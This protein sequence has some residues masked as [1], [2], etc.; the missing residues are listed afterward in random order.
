MARFDLQLL[1][2]YAPL[3]GWVMGGWLLGRWLP[4]T[5]PRYLGQGLFWVGVP[6]SII[7]FLRRANLSGA[8]WIA[9]IIAWLAIFLGVGL[10]WL[11]IQASLRWTN[12]TAKPPQVW[13]RSSQGSFLLTAMVGNT[14]YLGYP[15]ILTLVGP[16]YF[17]WA[18]FYDMLGTLLGSYG[19]GVL[20]AAQYGQ[21]R[22]STWQLMG[23]IAQNPA[24][25]SFGIGL[26][27]RQ[28]PLPPTLEIL[29]QGL[30]WTA[31]TLSLILIGMRLSQL[32][33]WR[34]LPRAS[35]SLGIKMLIVPLILG[36]GLTYLHLATP[37]Q[38]T[39]V[40]QTAMPPA[41]ATLVISEAYDLDR[42]L[43]VTTL[44]MGS[45]GL[46]VMLPVWLWLFGT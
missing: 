10:A 43:T 34:S 9:P 5:A 23:A 35:V 1:Q 11:W 31:L 29:L 4:A 13:N 7:A 38:L 36:W 28:V 19:F 25:W 21:R 15:I 45:V 41:F 46:L 18:L 20:L 3:I 14:G 32:T 12:R 24:L 40:L 44:A 16:Q 17:A 30:A 39:V 33:S 6:L 42:E 8:I 37:I 27:L 26:G 22:Y 2:L